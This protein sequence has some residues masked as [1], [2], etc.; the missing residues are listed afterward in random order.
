MITERYGFDVQ[1]MNQMS[2]NMCGSGAGLT[3][4]FFRRKTMPT[5]P[6]HQIDPCFAR[7]SEIASSD[8]DAL[9]QVV[10]Q[11]WKD[12]VHKPRGSRSQSR[13]LGM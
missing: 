8:L 5:E 3:A 9:I 10:D 4:Y 6:T 2:V 11:Q 13:L 1:F 12:N 7:A